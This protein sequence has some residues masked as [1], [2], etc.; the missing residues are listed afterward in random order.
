MAEMYRISGERLTAIADAIRE[1]KQTTALF[2]PE[3]MAAEIKSLAMGNDLQNA[4]DYTFGSASGYEHGITS[5]TIAR[6]E[7]NLHCGRKFTANVAISFMG[8]RFYS[9]VT[10]KDFVLTL[11]DAETQ[12]VLEQMTVKTTVTEE[13]VDYVLT[14]PRNL[15]PGK[16]YMIGFYAYKYS[17]FDLSTV[18]CNGKIT[19]IGNC[20]AY[21]ASGYPKTS[22]AD[23][24]CFDMLI[25][26][27]LGE[28][29][30]KE[31]KIQTETMNHIAD[32]IRRIGGVTGKIST[33]QML[34]LLKSM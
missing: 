23:Y 10:D 2:S 15:T 6:N 8:F 28:S 5:G 13:W 11:W 33:A 4:E 18:E 31:Y 32:E 3:Q 21:S 17:V 30:A 19:V 24:A 12:E 27:P 7:S 34:T 20:Y 22:S 14:E 1:K 9:I 25:G 16:T 29:V 26:D